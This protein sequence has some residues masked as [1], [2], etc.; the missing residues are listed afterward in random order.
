ML[1]VD[2]FLILRKLFFLTLILSVCTGFS[3]PYI[4][5]FKSLYFL[6]WAS[7]M[8]QM[9]K[10]PPAMQ[11]TQVQSLGQEDPLEKVIVT[12][13]SVLAWRIPWIVE[14]GELQFMGSQSDMTE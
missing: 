11:E 8:A 1:F 10:N 2:I 6:I 4:D 5:Q 3:Q 14:S 12:H 13:A 7:P 9:V